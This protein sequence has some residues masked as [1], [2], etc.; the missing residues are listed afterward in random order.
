M[1][2]QMPMLIGWDIGGAHLK[3]ALVDE[4][5]QAIKVFQ[6]S[7]PLWKGTTELVSAMQRMLKLMEASD[8]QHVVTMTGELVDYFP[9]RQTGVREIKH[10]V[11]SLL[12]EEVRFYAGQLGFISAEEVDS[13]ALHIASMNWHASASFVAKHVQDAL[14]IDIGSTTTDLIPVQ[15][16]QLMNQATTD[17]DRM[18]SNAL[19]YTG[20]IRT[21]LMAIGQKITFREKSY[22]VAAE[23]FATSADVYRLL[24]QLPECV[25]IAE[26]ADGQGKTMSETARRI[27]RMIGYDVDDASMQDWMALAEAFKALQMYQLRQAVMQYTQNNSVVLVGAGVGDFLV[28]EIATVLECTYLNVI[29]MIQAEERTTLQNAA[30][31]F[32]AYALACLAIDD[33]NH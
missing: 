14:F 20:V 22:H 7:C 15:A 27:A 6:L 29:D 2:D 21:P 25:D 16:K 31:C 4:R 11:I 24:G 17:A 8:V 33:G 18:A 13:N 1:Y 28:K 26:T 10:V 30:I 9:N 23:H 19:I 3:A 5:G 32:P 12:G